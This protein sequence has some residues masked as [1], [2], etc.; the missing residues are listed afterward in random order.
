MPRDVEAGTFIADLIRIGREQLQRS[1]GLPAEAAEEAMRQV[2]QAVCL[3]YARSEI[4]VPMMLD[5]RNQE[6]VRKY[7][8]PSRTAR[9]CT[10][11]RVVELAREYGMTTRWVYAILRDAIQADLAARQGTL[12]LDTEAQ[13]GR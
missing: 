2:A 12:D 7:H 6:I 11:R 5:P 8:E 1:C 3:Q 10:Y 4:Y 9:A 13:T